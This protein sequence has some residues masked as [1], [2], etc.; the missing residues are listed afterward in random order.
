ME[1]REPAQEAGVGGCRIRTRSVSMRIDY[2][3]VRSMPV[4]V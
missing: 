1:V 3:H 2:S 4:D